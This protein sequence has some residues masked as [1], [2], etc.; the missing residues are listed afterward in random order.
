MLSDLQ[1]MER[2]IADKT[3]NTITIAPMISAAEQIGPS[4]V[5]V[6]L[7]TE[8][9]VVERANRDHFDPLMTVKEYEEWLKHA[10]VANRY[11]IT[12][13]F[14]LHPWEFA[15]ASTLEFICLP[16]DILGHID[17][18]SSWARQ[19]L[20]VHSTAGNIHPGSRGFVVFELDNVGPVPILL[21][22]GMAIA[23]LT[24]DELGKPVDESYSERTKSKYLGFRQTLWSAYP[25]DSVLESMRRARDIQ[26]KIPRDR[27]RESEDEPLTNRFMPQMETE[28]IV[29]YREVLYGEAQTEFDRSVEYF[30]SNYLVIVEQYQDRYVAIIGSEIVDSDSDQTALS[31]R[32]FQRYGQRDIFMPFVTRGRR[33]PKRLGGPKKA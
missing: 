25:T 17:G 3:E 10:R 19:G 13:P 16:K 6:H 18:R 32:T 11:A 9:L 31:Q 8:F 5:D 28:M 14:V 7:G 4:S 15:L 29:P 12:D 21:Y 24:F 33:K 1:I 2:L 23:Q 22:P 26:R 30:E 20:Q 27:M